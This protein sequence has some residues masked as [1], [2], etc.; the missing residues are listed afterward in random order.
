MR[1]AAM[2]MSLVLPLSVSA[3]QASVAKRVAVVVALNRPSEQVEPVP[4]VH[5]NAAAL[6]EVL[7]S[8]AGYGDVRALIGPV[9]SANTVLATA[10]SAMEDVGPEGLVLFVYSGHGAGGDF[11]EPALLT[12]GASVAEPLAT[13][14]DVAELAKVLRPDAPGQQ[15][16]V[17]VDAAHLGSVDGVALMGPTASEWPETATSGLAVI[18]PN[19]AALGVQGSEIL[20]SLTSALSG[21]ADINEDGR[22]TLT[23]LFRAVGTELEDSSGSLIDTAGLISSERTVGVSKQTEMSAVL[24]EPPRFRGVSTALMA[25]GGAAG[26]ASLLMYFS[27]KGQ[28]ERQG[29]ELRCGDGSSYRRYQVSQHALGVLGGGLVVAGFGLRVLPT[30]DSMGIQV[31]GSF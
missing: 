16:V 12:H 25:T 22:V 8:S 28:C 27:K 6:V 20:P 13:G 11:G 26:A 2:I 17:V 14:L 9:A 7:S 30:A 19:F 1:F 4:N 3:G 5:E 29:G 15:V 21:A 23:E 24:P 18:T 10:R 31:R